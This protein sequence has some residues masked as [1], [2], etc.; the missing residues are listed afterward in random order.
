MNSAWS[1]SPTDGSPACGELPAPPRGGNYCIPPTKPELSE[2]KER[3][4]YA[5]ALKKVDGNYLITH[6]F[7][8]I[9]LPPF[10]RSQPLSQRWSQ[11]YNS[12]TMVER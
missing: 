6:G 11:N 12:E 3:G 9:N 4:Y 1:H 8:V 10:F 5:C 2:V 7:R